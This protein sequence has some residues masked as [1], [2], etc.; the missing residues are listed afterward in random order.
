MS[1]LLSSH[2]SESTNLD[3]W[4]GLILFSFTT[5]FLTEEAFRGVTRSRKVGWTREEGCGDWCGRVLFSNRDRAWEMKNVHN[6]SKSVDGPLRINIP[7]DAPCLTY[8]HLIPL[9]SLDLHQSQ[10]LPAQQKWGGHVHR[11]APRGDAPG[12]VAA[13]TLAL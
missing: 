7:R 10:E 13:F 5:E 12:G 8:P 2:R 9:N 1:F 11:S 3:Q 4:P 6:S